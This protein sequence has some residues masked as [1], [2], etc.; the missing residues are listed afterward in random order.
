[1]VKIAV[2]ILDHLG[3][4]VAHA[5][6]IS[7]SPARVNRVAAEIIYLVSLL[8]GPGVSVTIRA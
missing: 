6:S 5:G 1:V 8:T 7:T 4:D 3:G 2:F